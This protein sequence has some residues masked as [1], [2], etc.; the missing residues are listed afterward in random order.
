MGLE[1]KQRQ[2]RIFISQEGYTREILNKFN[3]LNYNPINT[4][5]ECGIKLSKFD[6]GYKND[7]IIF[8]SFVGSLRYMTCTRTNILFTIRVLSHFMKTPNS[9]HMKSMKRIIHY[10]KGTINYEL[11]YYLSIDFKLFGFCDI[12]FV[13]DV[14]DRKSITI[15]VFFVGDYAITWSLKK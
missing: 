6:E 11:F 7:S 10:L 12:D 14:D 9:T 5:I 3:M 8:K 4:P 2:D 1:V 15:F 13:G